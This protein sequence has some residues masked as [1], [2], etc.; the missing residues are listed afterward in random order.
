MSLAS[1]DCSLLDIGGATY[2]W[3]CLLGVAA[4]HFHVSG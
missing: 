4:V 1:K 3:L 2:Y